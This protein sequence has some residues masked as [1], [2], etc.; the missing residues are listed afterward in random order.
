MKR[1]IVV[2]AAVGAL[3]AAA[4][5]DRYERP[6]GPD[7]RIGPEV[8]RICFA[9][10]INNW[11]EVDGYDEAV[12]L[13]RGVND[14][15]YVSLSGACDRYLF[16]HAF[17]IGLDVRPGGGCVRRGDVIVVRDPSYFN[18]RCII[19]RINEWNDRARPG[20]AADEPEETRT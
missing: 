9:S 20:G 13:E 14:W 8:D 16:R 19:T 1:T 12:L 18:R 6:D 15:Y 17:A 7:P 2:A 5:A 4:A 10:T 3:T 11:K